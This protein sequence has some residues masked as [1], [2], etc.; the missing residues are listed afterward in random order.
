MNIK[1]E[2]LKMYISDYICNR[3]GDFEIDADKIADT[4]ALK[5]LDDIQKVI[6]NGVY[7][8]FEKIEKIVRIFENNK[9]DTGN[10]H[11]F[12]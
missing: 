2:L 10:C 6:E 12:S 8:D 3:I 5:M 7:S 11:D 9:I 4:A 1:T